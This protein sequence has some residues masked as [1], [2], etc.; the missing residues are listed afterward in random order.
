MMTLNN[1]KTSRKT[2]LSVS[3][4]LAAIGFSATASADDDLS[5]LW[6]KGKFTVDGRIRFEGVDVDKQIP[7]DTIKNAKAWT[8]RI[9]PGFQ[10]GVWN[11]FS[12]VVEGEATA[13]LN[14][15]FNS[16]R[17]GETGY[18]A[19][20]DPKNLELNQLNLKYAYSPKFDVTVGRQRINLDNQ[21]FVGGVAWRQNEQTFDAVSLNLNPTKEL[22]LYYAYIDHVNAIFGTE[23]I[24][25]AFNN[26]QNGRIDSDS[27]LLQLKYAPTPLFNAVA[28]GYLL[29]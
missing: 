26:A 16:T 11:G 17:N 15:S 14:D 4:M 1:P 8:A 6:K 12:G 24:K 29:D 10:T 19:V 21:R 3:V 18:A 2:L 13:D 7:S 25:P 9:R 23:D 20:S 27:H 28:Y 22:G 5:N